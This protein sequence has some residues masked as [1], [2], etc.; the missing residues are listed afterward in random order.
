MSMPKGHKSQHGYATL[1]IEGGLGFREISEKMT[2]D[3]DEMNHATAR[4]ILLRGLKK[5]ST[6]LL[7]LHGVKDEDMESE[8]IRVAC[9]PRF[10]RALIDII[11]E[12][13]EKK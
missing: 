11:T 3:G 5:V 10:Q 9:D 12:K 2:A 13:M 4:N 7:K 1:D 8:S 6:P